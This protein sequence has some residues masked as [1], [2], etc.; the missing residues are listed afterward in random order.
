MLSKNY[1]CTTLG[2]T[3]TT[4]QRELRLSPMIIAFT[5]VLYLKD[6]SYSYISINAAIK[7]LLALSVTI[8]KGHKSGYF[9]QCALTHFHSNIHLYGK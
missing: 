6:L 2:G 5:A 7:P 3:L 9:L 4:T 8:F 1:Y